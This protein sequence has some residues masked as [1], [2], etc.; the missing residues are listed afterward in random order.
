MGQLIEPFSFS[1]KL[2]MLFS[3]YAIR[4]AYCTPI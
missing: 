3:V 4:A 2:F 1:L